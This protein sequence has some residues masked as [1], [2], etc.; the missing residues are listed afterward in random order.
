M[1]F[2]F[3]GLVQPDFG[4]L[5]ADEFNSTWATDLPLFYKKRRFKTD[6]TVTA[7][8]PK[9]TGKKKSVARPLQLYS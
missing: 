1:S 5:T 2:E 9:E 6:R 8:D 7:E 4:V 3:G